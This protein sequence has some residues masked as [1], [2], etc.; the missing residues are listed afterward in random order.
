MDTVDHN[1][2]YV[3]EFDALAIDLNVIPPQTTDSFGD[4][5]GLL[6]DHLALGQWEPIGG[7]YPA[8]EHARKVAAE[9]GADHG[10]IYL[11]GQTSQLYEDS[12]MA[13]E[14]RQRRYFFYLSGIDFANCIVTYEIAQD[15]LILWI[16]YTDP[17]QTL[18]YGTT[19]GIDDCKAV[20]EVDQ[21]FW[22][23]ELDKYLQGY[24]T[25]YPNTTLFAL[26]AGQVPRLPPGSAP[27]EIDAIRLHSAMD[28]AR[29]VK[30]DYE[31]ALIR[32][33]NA[34]SS[35]AHRA[36]LQRLPRLTNEREI[37]ALFRAVCTAR[38]ARRQAYPVIAGSGPNAGT[39][40]YEDN[41]QP[42]AGR[43]VVVVDA[44]C[45]WRCYASDVTR[46]YPLGGYGSA[47]SAV[48]A[49]VECMQEACIS[50][51]APGRPFRELHALAC[52]V[53]VRGLLRLGILR[54]GSVREI[55]D[56]GTVAAFFP[57]S[58]GHHVGLEVHDVTG[59][60][61]LLG[62]PAGHQSI[63]EQGRGVPCLGKR[64][65]LSDRT[66]AF[67]CRR[68]AASS[69]QG[70]DGSQGLEKNMIVTIEPGIYFCRPY[71]EA[72]FLEK[73]IHAKYIDKVVLEKYYDVGGVRI[74]DDILVTEDGYENLTTAPKGQE[75]IRSIWRG[76]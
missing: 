33:A 71:I 57:H 68:T 60:Q 65:I 59:R 25:T 74:E 44:G 2:V 40:H 24:F 12:D 45:E 34:V 22:V 26:H 35:E 38:G 13:P 58:L 63:A 41:D 42:L 7:K 54:G 69:E 1:L 73:A 46:T 49:V 28:A 55:L 8:K 39:L 3:D 50:R 37:E 9:L 76:Y 61:R 32:R 64:E 66:Q 30:T 10:V 17:R 15:R 51:V 16:P 23:S 72:Y 36:V 62:L 6:S 52:A 75:A 43:Q 5:G 56:A 29:V 14:F 70:S 19:P 27:V 4:L 47:A 53:A 31:V 11:V 18:W 20:S 48:Y 21:V 67:L